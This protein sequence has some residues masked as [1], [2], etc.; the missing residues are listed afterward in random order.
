MEKE[1]WQWMVNWH[2][3]LYGNKPCPFD[4]IVSAPNTIGIQNGQQDIFLVWLIFLMPCHLVPKLPNSFALALTFRLSS[5]LAW[6]LDTFLQEV[7][8]MMLCMGETCASGVVLGVILM[9]WLWCRKGSGSPSWYD[10][11]CCKW[12]VPQICGRHR[13]DVSVKRGCLS[14]LHRVAQDHETGWVSVY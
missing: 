5:R 1:S 6:P 11:W 10:W 12:P 4:H 3:C 8:S 13:F 9:G 7:C 14:I 2:G